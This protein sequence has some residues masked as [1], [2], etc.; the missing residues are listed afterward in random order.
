MQAAGAAVA[1]PTAREVPRS[2][3]VVLS[4]HLPPVQVGFTVSDDGVRGVA[5]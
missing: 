4:S 3:S 1:I 2:L 5:K